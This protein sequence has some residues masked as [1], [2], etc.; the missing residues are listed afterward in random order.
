LKSTLKE[1]FANARALNE[2]VTTA[3]MSLHVA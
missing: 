2:G 3:I 1:L